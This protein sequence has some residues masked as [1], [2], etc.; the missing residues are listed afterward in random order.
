M[1][2]ERA[3]AHPDLVRDVAA[4]G[5]QVMLHGQQHHSFLSQQPRLL[6]QSLFQARAHLAFTAQLH[7]ERV[8]HVRPPYGLISP[9]VVRQ[10]GRWGYRPVMGSIAPPHWHQPGNRTV[11]QVAAHVQ[12]G[13]LI[14]LHESQRGPSVDALTDQI[15][16]RVAD[17]GLTLIT[18]EQMWSERESLRCPAGAGG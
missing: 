13:T 7:P 16:R 4:A 6:R 8:T 18:V 15:L 3:S 17:R 11:R 12:N 9:R 10:L 2:G 14:V 5:H 1:I